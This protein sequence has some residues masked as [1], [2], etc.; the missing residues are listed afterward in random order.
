MRKCLRFLLIA[1]LLSLLV[2]CSSEDKPVVMETEIINIPLAGDRYLELPVPADDTLISTDGY[3]VWNYLSGGNIT[4]YATAN[5]SYM[6]SHA[7]EVVFSDTESNVSLSIS[8]NKDWVKYLETHGS[9]VK[10]KSGT[11]VLNPENQLEEL[12]IDHDLDYV[13]CVTGVKMPGTYYTNSWLMP[14][15]KDGLSYFTT[16]IK[17][18]NEDEMKEFALSYLKAND[19]G[20]TMWFDT[21]EHFLAY[22]DKVGIGYKKLT[23]NK[24][25][26]Y[27]SSLD[28]FDYIVLNMQAVIFEWI[29]GTAI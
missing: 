4:K 18:W 11:L 22:N 21:G 26:V 28:N 29:S 24:Y 9:D 13:D 19:Y 5:Q 14:T 7:N 27:M 25:V 12:Q 20:D 17:Y 10:I 15:Y 8:G 2:G 6:V 16:G 3:V 23:V 1:G